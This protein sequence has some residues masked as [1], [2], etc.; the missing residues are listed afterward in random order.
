MANVRL[1]N[2]HDGEVSAL[3]IHYL[4]PLHDQLQN[5]EWLLTAKGGLRTWLGRLRDQRELFPVARRST[6]FAIP[7]SFVILSISSMK[8]LFR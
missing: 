3:L 4:V 7:I 2:D 1:T 8:K 5:L 6:Y